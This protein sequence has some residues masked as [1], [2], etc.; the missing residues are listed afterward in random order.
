M[1]RNE[2]DF[3]N[4]SKRTRINR[5]DSPD[6]YRRSSSL[7]MDLPNLSTASKS[8][9]TS[10]A[11]SLRPVIRSA[12]PE[13]HNL[14][15][16]KRP[17]AGGKAGQA[18]QFHVNHFKCTLPK[19]L[20]VNQYD[21]DV[22]FKMRDG[23]W[24]SAKKEDRFAVMQKIIEREKF[25]FVWYDDGKN[26]YSL[27]SL[28]AILNKSYEIVM[29][30]KHNDKTNTYQFILL[31]LVKTYSISDIWDFI[32]KRSP[33]KPHDPVRVLETLLKQQQKCQMISVK[34]QFYD[35]NQRLDDL[36]DGRGL[37]QGF[38]QAMFLTQCG[39]TLNINATFTCFYHGMD[40]VRFVSDYLQQDITKRGIPER[41]QQLLIK[42]I[43]KPIWV[44]TR[45][46]GP[47][48]KYRIKGFGQ[49]SNRH[50][51]PKDR[52]DENDPHADSERISV[53]DYF[54]T[55]Y[56]TRLR[57]P[58]L[59]TVELY[60][61][62]N[63]AQSHF[64]PMELCTVQEW[65][66]SMKPL[67]TEQRSRVTKKTVIRPD[68][69]Y[70]TIMRV[71][72][73]RRF[74]DDVYLK[75]IGMQVEHRGKLEK[76][77]MMQ[78]PARVLPAPDIKYRSARDNSDAVERV[79]FGKWNLRNRLT[80]TREIKSWA[81]ILVSQ[82]EPQNREMDVAAQFA[83]RF[84]QIIEKFGVRFL[85]A[86][87]QKS[88]PA[89]PNVILRRLEELKERKCEV[90]VFILNNCGE[91]IYKAIKYFGNQKLGIVTQ[92]TSF[93][94][95]QKNIGKL[96]MYLNNLVQKF[97]AKLGGMN[98]VVALT[99][100]L[101]SANTRDDVFMFFGA[102]VTHITCS[103]EKP[104]VA[105]VLGSRDSTSTQYACRIV[106]QFPSKGKI[107]LEIIKDLYGIATDLLK[108]FA[109]SNGR[110]PTK[111]VF[112]RNGVDDGHFHKVLD[113]EVRALKN[114]CKALYG[115]NP[116][117]KITF[118]AI[119][120][121]HNTR[122]FVYD[123]RQNRTDNVQPGTVVDSTVTHPTQFD[124]FLNSHAAI[125]G[126]S[127]PVLYHVLYDE[128][129]FSSDEIQQLTYYLCHTDVRCT[130]SVSVPVHYAQL[131]M[132]RSHDSDYE[133]SRSS[134]GG[135]SD[136]VDEI[137]EN[138]TVSLEDVQTKIMQFDPSIQ[139]TMWYV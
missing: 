3:D 115:H 46:T 98:Q 101:T 135:D 69:R 96:D 8:R 47:I 79:N 137:D 39:P 24:R 19:Q 60:N 42:K 123:A 95:I 29:K 91:D 16:A 38:Y 57:Y 4:P 73:D 31:N 133:A 61:L 54:K 84:P 127:R 129:G 93:P 87:I 121:R 5:D 14:T 17:D 120:K 83:Q 55:K 82:R 1:R 52:K 63:K 131:A 2:D 18:V 99:R 71:V 7:V 122:F 15:L 40:L 70:D 20:L 27:E 65:Q 28:T 36:G 13:T 112:Y 85:S 45:H 64:L 33:I 110:L 76:D 94:A 44:E 62:G 25:P 9:L 12:I 23:S 50:T 134:V 132:Y 22:E 77:Y 117:P 37:A 111:I 124:F 11:K 35:R 68:R 100:A 128:I 116:P 75:Q 114:A 10:R 136:M 108:I 106:E 119:R 139:D 81:C 86:A 102:D 34:N 92:C 72:Q 88:D 130:K 32:E 43:L 30:N 105:A 53:A 48:R 118:I 104:S 107:A 66:R 59:P 103:R 90:V 89:V 58:D 67:T 109:T 49:S 80:K 138:V 51:F 126:T 125:Q 6:R 26:L 78:I 113:N 97:N 74:D 41:E 21:M 56:D